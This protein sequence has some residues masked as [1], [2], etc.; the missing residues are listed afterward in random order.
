MT[1]K[2]KTAFSFIEL[3]I[4]VLIIG[5]LFGA[6]FASKAVIQTATFNKAKTL[7][8]NSIV[9]SM[10]GLVLWLESTT[11]ESFDGN[12]RVDGSVISTWYDISPQT[13]SP[14]NATQTGADSLKPT[15]AKSG[16]NGLPA[17]E[18]D[19]TDNLIGG[20]LG[21]SGSGASTIFIVFEM[22]VKVLTGT[23]IFGFGK[24]T[25]DTS[26]RIKKIDVQHISGGSG[27]RFNNGNRRFNENITID[28]PY[29]ST[30][31]NQDGATYEQ[32]DRYL[33]GTISTEFST[34][35][36][37][38]I[39][40][41]LDDEYTVGD[42]RSQTGVLNKPFFGKIGEIIIFNRSLNTSQ[43]EEIEKYL[44][45]KWGIDLS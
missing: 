40:D 18:F 6:V 36:G 19:G 27:F 14:N 12:E 11:L 16:I 28:T 37:T 44:S 35:S 42:A 39:P 33:N 1:H 10:D 2:T 29:V 43:R 26:G 34:T 13:K 32:H 41:I 3:A 21:I 15:Y 30:Y 22:D 38:T 8:K 7:T 5:A 23:L 24:S 31:T 9:N 4:S 20:P 17:L 25:N 45:N